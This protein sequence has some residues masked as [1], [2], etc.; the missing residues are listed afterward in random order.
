MT[1]TSMLHETHRLIGRLVCDTE[2]GRTGVLRAIAPDGN[3]PKPVAWLSPE[4]GGTEWTTS[5]RSV[6]PVTA[7]TPSRSSRRGR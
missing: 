1:T 3:A 2:S 6:E 7:P 5:L 4:G